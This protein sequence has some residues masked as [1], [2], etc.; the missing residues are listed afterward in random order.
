MLDDSMDKNLEVRMSDGTLTNTT[1]TF[2]RSKQPRAGVST[3]VAGAI[4]RAGAGGVRSASWRQVLPSAGMEFY[5]R[6]AVPFLCKVD[7]PLREQENT[8]P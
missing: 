8:G 2:R 4:D 1:P 5:L 6:S 7:L 3:T